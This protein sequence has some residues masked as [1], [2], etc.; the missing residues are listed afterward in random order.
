MH[1]KVHNMPNDGL[2]SVMM[3]V[4]HNG[5]YLSETIKRLAAKTNNQIS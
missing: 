1:R 5:T 2:N 3:K 4:T